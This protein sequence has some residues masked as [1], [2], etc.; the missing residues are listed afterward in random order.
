MPTTTLYIES[1]VKQS[2]DESGPL[3]FTINGERYIEDCDKI[4]EVVAKNMSEKIKHFDIKAIHK[5][6]ASEFVAILNDA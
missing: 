5:T 4:N 6:G 1:F 2:Y 3:V